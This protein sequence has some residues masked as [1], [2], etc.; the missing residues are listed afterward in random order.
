MG[1]A[2]ASSAVDEVHDEL[3]TELAIGHNGTVYMAIDPSQRLPDRDVF[4]G[5]EMSHAE[6]IAAA[7]HLRLVE[8]T[9]F[10]LAS[11]GKIYGSAERVPVEKREGRATFRGYAM[12]AE[13]REI[14]LDELHRTAF[15]LTVAIQHEIQQR[16][17]AA[18][19]KHRRDAKKRSRKA[20]AASKKRSRTRGQAPRLAG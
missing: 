1:Q 9:G 4:E 14:G 2:S 13:E 5:W 11:D 15:N 7:G 12:T 17:V 8:M 10:V 16:R 18:Q 6:A 19:K 20:P 3:S